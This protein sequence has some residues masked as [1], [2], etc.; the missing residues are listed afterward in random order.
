VRVILRLKVN[1]AI[2]I[3]FDDCYPSYETDSKE[4]AIC[5]M[6]DGIQAVYDLDVI[7]SIEWILR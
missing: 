6:E 5:D 7:Y 3:Q 1:P 2:P 4:L